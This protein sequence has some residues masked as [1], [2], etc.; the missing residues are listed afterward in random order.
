MVS[1]PNQMDPKKFEAANLRILFV[2]NSHTRTSPSFLGIL[3]KRSLPENH[4]LIARSMGGF[5]AD[6]QNHPNTLNLIDYGQWD[7]VILQ[8]QKYSTSGK[9]T[10]PIEGAVTLVKRAQAQGAEVIMFPEWSRQEVPDEYKRIDRIHEQISSKTGAQVA[11]IGRTWEVIQKEFPELSLYHADGNHASP[12]GHFV[13]ACV[14]FL[15]IKSHMSQDKAST[16]KKWNSIQWE[17]PIEKQIF[18]IVR[19]SL[20]P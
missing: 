17:R 2:G 8:A 9:Y 6:H 4:I 16:S 12:D 13:N 3:L 10:Y 19:Q 14:F 15:L 11:P 7:F 5:L 18:D 1:S 20:N